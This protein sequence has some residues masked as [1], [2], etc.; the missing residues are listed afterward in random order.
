VLLER[1]AD[2]NALD[3]NG[4]TPLDWIDRASKSVDRA[5]VIA[6]VRAFTK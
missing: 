2:P 6:S 1:G 4:H 5:A 3:D